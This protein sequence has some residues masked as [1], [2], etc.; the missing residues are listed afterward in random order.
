MGLWEFPGWFPDVG[1]W[2]LLRRPHTPTSDHYHGKSWRA[3]NMPSVAPLSEFTSGKDA[4]DIPIPFRMLTCR[5]TPLE[6][7]C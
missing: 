7:L 4:R 5:D 1:V 6:C 3:Q 2:G